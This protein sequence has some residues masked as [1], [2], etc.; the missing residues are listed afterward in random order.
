MKP[1]RKYFTASGL[2]AARSGSFTSCASL[3]TPN[4]PSPRPMFNCLSLLWAALFLPRGQRTSADTPADSSR[5][6]DHKLPQEIDMSSFW[7]KRR[8]ED[9]AGRNYHT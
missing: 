4:S 9:A 1:F 3:T 2:E 7:K 8:K 5:P 6:Q